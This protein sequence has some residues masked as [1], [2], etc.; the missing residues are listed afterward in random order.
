[1]KAGVSLYC[2]GVKE[3]GNKVGSRSWSGGD[4]GE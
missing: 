2:K 3:E 1:M 4:G